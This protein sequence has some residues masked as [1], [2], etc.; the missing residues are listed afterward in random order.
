MSQTIPH[1][2]PAAQTRPPQPKALAK[3]NHSESGNAVNIRF[4]SPRSL[5]VPRSLRPSLSPSPPLPLFFIAALLLCATNISL[6]PAAQDPLAAKQQIVQDR[7]AQLE[8]RMFRLAEKLAETDPHQAQRLTDAL[9]KA[10][11]ALLRRNMAETITLLEQA[12]LAEAADHMQEI[13]D[14]LEQLL[15]ILLDDPDQQKR[16]QEELERLAEIR[17]QLDG[18]IDRQQQLKDRI[19]QV[20]APAGELAEI[21]AAIAR[22]ETLIDRQKKEIAKNTATTQPEKSAGLEESQKSLRQDTNTLADDLRQM[23]KSITSRPGSQPTTPSTEE[24]AKSTEQAGNHMQAAEKPLGDGQPEQARPHQEQALQDLQ[25]A[26]EQMQKQQKTLREEIDLAKAAE[27]QKDL[28]NATDKLAEEMQ[29]KD[30]SPTD[31]TEN[32]RK[33]GKHM[34]QAAQELDQ[35]NPGQAAENQRQALDELKQAREELE[36]ILEQ[37]RREQQEEILRGLESRFRI[38]LAEQMKVNQTTQDLESKGPPN[39]TREDELTLAGTAQNQ[40]SLVEQAEQA[41]RILKEEGTTIVFPRM[42]EQL[43]EDMRDSRGRLQGKDTGSGTQRIQVEIVNTLKELIEAI[44]KLREE[45][46]PGGEGGGGQETGK[47]P[48]P[49]LP[50]SA[51]LKLLRSC[52]QRVNRDTEALEKNAAS[53]A[54]PDPRQQKDRTRLAE[55]QHEL[56][57]MA[58]KMHERIT[59]R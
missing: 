52:Q 49:L 46:M 39:W 13:G 38:M 48:P 21:Q 19:E 37:K 24:A 58:G 3:D 5:S 8:D 43:C 20:Q 17:K 55:R 51:E 18:L 41:L 56:A 2:Q 42:V 33:A 54:L 11:E 36:R 14:G 16:L 31:G 29:G 35:E 26:L 53:G 50:G 10:R 9:R 32:V 44:Q 28:K 22:L 7:M 59:G 15:K 1:Y 57:E 4:H 45:G 23:G 47:Q 40:G 25:K 12:R 34:D 27:E 30:P 6:L